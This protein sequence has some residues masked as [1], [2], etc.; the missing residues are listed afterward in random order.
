MHLPNQPSSAL[1]RASTSGSCSHVAQCLHSV[2]V[3]EPGCDNLDFCTQA[4]DTCS[5]LMAR[6][7]TTFIDRSR[8][9]MQD[10][11]LG[12]TQAQQGPHK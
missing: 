2:V 5:A 11:Q 12:R 1:K 6:C 10:K 8:F 7:G 9:S 4:P 3:S